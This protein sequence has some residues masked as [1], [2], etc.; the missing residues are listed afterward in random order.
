MQQTR[1]RLKENLI[2]FRQFLLRPTEVSAV[3][4]TS[5]AL[6]RVLVEKANIRHAKT[7]VELGPGTGAATT[8]INE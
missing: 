8:I 1:S 7:I 2:F 3:I 6:S 5:R 4:P